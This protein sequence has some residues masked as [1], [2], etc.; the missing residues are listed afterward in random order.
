MHEASFLTHHLLIF[1]EL[2]SL[3]NLG[4]VFLKVQSA[5]SL[6]FSQ[7]LQAINNTQTNKN[8]RQTVQSYYK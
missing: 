7:I 5:E 8:Q 3:K 6:K 2:C 4:T 1:L